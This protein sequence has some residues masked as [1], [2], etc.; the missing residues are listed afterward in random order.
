VTSRAR[1]AKTIQ[2][3]IENGEIVACDAGHAAAMI[4]GVIEGLLLQA[5]ADPDFDPQEAWPTTWQILSA[6]MTPRP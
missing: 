4:T 6:G 3:G 5:L 1:L 2:K